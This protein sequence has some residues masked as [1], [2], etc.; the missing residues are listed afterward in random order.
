LYTDDA[1][2]GDTL[3]QLCGVLW[4]GSAK[5]FKYMEVQDEESYQVRQFS[6]FISVISL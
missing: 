1:H 6:W 3:Y 2:A 5:C 4:D